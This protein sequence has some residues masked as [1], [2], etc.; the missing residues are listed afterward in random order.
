VS[1]RPRLAQIDL[2]KGFAVLGVIALHALDQEELRDSWQGLHYGQ[3]VAIFLLLM[4]LNASSSLRARAG[5]PLRALFT[6]SYFAGRAERLL[7]PF[8]LVWLA[9]VAFGMA[10]DELD[11]GPTTL[12][13]ALPLPGPGNYFITIAFEFVLVFPLLLWAFRRAPRATIA[14]C[15]AIAAAFELVAPHVFSGPYPYPYDAAIVRYF[16]QVALGLWIAEHMSIGDRGNRWILAA[17]PLSIAYLV[18]QHEHPET[19]DWLRND[20]GTTTNFLAA[21]HTALLVLLGL[22]FLPRRETFA[23]VR[24]LAAIGRASWHIFL[25]QIVW[26]MVYDERGLDAFAINAA[27]PCAI[28]YALFRVMALPP[29]A[30]RIRTASRALA[31]A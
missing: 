16:G 15:F 3:A 25:V 9:S 26:F 17:A 21:F 18:V 23:P 1:A 28:G 8:A 10:E 19:F 13:G 31:R 24:V 11:F 12:V 20:F 27:V 29:V 6:R 5:G 7:A 14:G 30:G 22:R 4:A 2:L